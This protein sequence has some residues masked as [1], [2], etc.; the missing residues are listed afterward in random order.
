MT[1]KT[2][3]TEK[4]ASPPLHRLVTLSIPGLEEISVRVE[5]KGEGFTELSLAA[6]PQNPLAVLERSQALLEFVTDEGMFRMLG[7]IRLQASDHGDAIRFEHQGRVQLLQR[8][9]H[10]RTDCIAMVV[11][12]GES[13]TPQRGMTLNLSGGGLLLRGLAG[14]EVGDELAF[15]LRLDLLPARI[16]GRCRVVRQT[17]DGF[18]GVQFTEIDEASRDKLVRFAFQ[19]ENAAR[20]ARLGY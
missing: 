17:P 16:Q 12:T 5:R 11:M 15:D 2:E 9:A 10:V 19:R 3:K 14:A 20:Q 6:R 8:R 4:T 1:E 18:H 13:G 7:T